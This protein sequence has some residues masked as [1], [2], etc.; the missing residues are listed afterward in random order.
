MSHPPEFIF[1]QPTLL[2]LEHIAAISIFRNIPCVRFSAN[3]LKI[4]REAL[5]STQ[6]KKL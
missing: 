6:K 4:C 5:L 3:L 1:I 2:F